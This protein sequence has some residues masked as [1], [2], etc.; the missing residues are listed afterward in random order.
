LSICFLQVLPDQLPSTDRHLEGRATR[1]HSAR[2]QRRLHAAMAE[3]MAWLPSHPIEALADIAGKWRPY[4]SWVS[5][6]FVQNSSTARTRLREL[7]G[8]QLMK[9]FIRMNAGGGKKLEDA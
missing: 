5:V 9:S 3:H 2:H 7:G 4:R 1:D 8:K 6:L